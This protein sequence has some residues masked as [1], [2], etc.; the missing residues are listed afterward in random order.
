MLVIPKMLLISQG[1]WQVVANGVHYRM[2]GGREATKESPGFSQYASVA[3]AQDFER[4]T[5]V[6]EIM[7]GAT[8]IYLR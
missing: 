7:C 4:K 2:V 1:V 5:Q 6:D 8:I 3:L